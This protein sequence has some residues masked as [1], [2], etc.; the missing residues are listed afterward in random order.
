MPRFHE[1]HL[2]LTDDDDANRQTHADRQDVLITAGGTMLVGGWGLHGA[3]DYYTDDETTNF[4]FGGWLFLIGA[5]L[6]TVGA[7]LVAVADTNLDLFW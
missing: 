5:L 6:Q 7:M 3:G 1:A 4:E 2:P